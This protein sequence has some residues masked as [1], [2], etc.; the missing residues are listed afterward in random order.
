MTVGSVAPFVPSASV[1]LC[2]GA[3]ISLC[4]SY[5]SVFKRATMVLALAVHSTSATATVPLNILILQ[6]LIKRKALPANLKCRLVS[7]LATPPGGWQE[8]EIALQPC[9]TRLPAL[10]T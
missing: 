1:H 5:T 10:I 8:A 7:R 4:H 6:D 2:V 3:S 9:L